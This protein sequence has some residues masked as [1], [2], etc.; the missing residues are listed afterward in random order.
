MVA[1]LGP[2]PDRQLAGSPARHPG[3]PPGKFPMAPLAPLA[4]WAHG[5]WVKIE[6]PE[7]HRNWS[8]PFT[9]RATHLRL[10]T[11]FDPRRLHVPLSPDEAP[12]RFLKFLFWGSFLMP[13][14]TSSFLP[15]KYETL[16]QGVELVLSCRNGSFGC[17]LNVRGRTEW[18]GW[19]MSF[20]VSSVF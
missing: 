17:S 3:A 15:K 8:C 6:P 14:G 19:L 9:D 12:G 11:I 20:W 7:H 2:P 1:P 13:F 16:D 4:P 18:N 10:P 5:V